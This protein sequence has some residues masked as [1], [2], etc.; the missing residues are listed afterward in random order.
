MVDQ[1]CLLEE[2][3]AGD[4]TQDPLSGHSAYVSMAEDNGGHSSEMVIAHNATKPDGPNSHHPCEQSLLAQ[5]GF[6]DMKG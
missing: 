2:D 6:A 5:T 3:D 4:E 1:L